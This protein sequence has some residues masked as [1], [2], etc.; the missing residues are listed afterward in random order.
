MASVFLLFLTSSVST[1]STEATLNKTAPL[2]KLVRGNKTIDLQRL[3]GEYVLV[4]FW[5]VEDAQ[6]RINN[7][8]YD[9]IVKNSNNELNFISI[10]I[11]TDYQLY[12]QI[13]EIDKLE[14]RNQYNHSEI[15][16]GKINSE[17]LNERG[18][19]AYLIN[20]KGEIEKINPNENQ[21]KEKLN[22]Q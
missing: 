16:Y 3:R 18:Y 2:F 7:V 9:R 1:E 8:R 20:P 22:F 12:S 17:W 5:S 11:D 19:K 13:L 14:K 6:S 15:V 4:N 21:L 10:N